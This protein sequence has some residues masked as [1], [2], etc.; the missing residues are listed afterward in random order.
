[1][2]AHAATSTGAP[3]PSL[4]PHALP[5]ETAA[6]VDEL[7]PRDKAGSG[8]QGA[9]PAAAAAGRD[10]G[11]PRGGVMAARVWMQ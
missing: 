5:L 1:M 2:R 7:G 10:V 9:V 6:S 8:M 3:Q 11:G 4:P